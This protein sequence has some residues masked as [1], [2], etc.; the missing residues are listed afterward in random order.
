MSAEGPLA[1]GYGPTSRKVQ[2]QGFWQEARFLASWTSPQG[3][4]ECP[5]DMQHA[6]VT[7][8]R[9]SGEEATAPSCEVRG[10]SHCHF[11][12]F[13]LVGSESLSLM[14]FKGQGTK[15][16]LGEECQGI[17]GP[18]ARSGANARCLGGNSVPL[19]DC[20]RPGTLV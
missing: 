6:G 14:A 9:E 15:L 11:H 8:E 12:G 5:R 20:G 18:T 2:S 17:C 19:L 7:Q 10:A 3:P 4:F 13:L 16:P 1:G